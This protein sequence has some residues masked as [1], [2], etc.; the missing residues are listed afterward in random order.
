MPIA[1]VH[2]YAMVRLIS[3]NSFCCNCVLCWHGDMLCLFDK[4]AVLSQRWPRNTPYIRGCPE[5][6]RDSLT[7][8]TATIPKFF[9][10][11]LFWS[12]VWMFLQNLKS[13]ALPVPEI[14]GVPQKWAVSGFAHAPFSAKFLMSFCSDWPYK[15]TRQIWSPQL[16]PFLRRSNYV[17]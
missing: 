16:Y 14:I 17:G 6:F 10:G 1:L 5:N 3:V 8:P 2:R 11:L 7:T 4:K 15:C 9:H 13:V 12:T